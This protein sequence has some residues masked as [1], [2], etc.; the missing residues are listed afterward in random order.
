MLHPRKA[1]IEQGRE[2][3][4]T[5]DEGCRLIKITKDNAK[6]CDNECEYGEKSRKKALFLLLDTHSKHFKIVG[7]HIYP[8]YQRKSAAMH[9]GFFRR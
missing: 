3:D 6:R 4:R 2:D 1:H 5:A 7:N 9:H 8:P